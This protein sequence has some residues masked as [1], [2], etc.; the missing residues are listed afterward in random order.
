MGRSW[1]LLILYYAT[2]VGG[3][4]IGHRVAKKDASIRG[5]ASRVRL[6]PIGMNQI[7]GGSTLQNEITKDEKGSVFNFKFDRGPWWAY[8]IAGSLGG[9]IVCMCVYFCFCGKK[10]SEEAEP[11]T[12]AVTSSAEAETTENIALSDSLLRELVCRS[13]QRVGPALAKGQALQNTVQRCIEALTGNAQK[14]VLSELSCTAGRICKTLEAEEAMLVLDWDA[15]VR[16]NFPA[17]TVLLAGLLAPTILQL[18][19]YGHVTMIALLLL[20]VA[21]LC[22]WAAW[23]DYGVPC[24]AIPTLFTWLYVQGAIAAVLVLTRLVMVF[25]IRAGQAKLQSKAKEFQEKRNGKTVIDSLGE[26]QELFVTHSVLVQHAL[27]IEESVTKSLWS[28]I[29]G[30]GTLL[31]IIVTMWG[32]VL[33]LGWTFV[34]GIVAFHHDAVGVHDYCGAWATVF[35]ARLVVII[36]ILFFLTNVVSTLSWISNLALATPWFQGKA[37]HWARAFDAR[38]QGLPVMQVLFKAFV[39]P[40]ELDTASAQLAAELYEQTLMEQEYS[41]CDQR[42]KELK[43]QIHTQ[44]QKADDLRKKLFTEGDK[45]TLQADLA[46]LEKKSKAAIEKGRKSVEEGRKSIS[47]EAIEA[48]KANALTVEEA[49]TQELERVFNKIREAAEAGKGKMKEFSESEQGQQVRAAVSSAGEKVTVAAERT[50]AVAKE[51]AAAAQDQA[52][53]SMAKDDE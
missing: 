4:F 33:V 18:N 44:K 5:G 20:P 34:P 52:K 12:V 32:T 11:K 39:L 50:A 6:A 9:L 1:K 7:R 30:F 41:T 17:V 42:V 2:C 40:R 27:L 25:Q 43:N 48:A 24:A 15:A 22:A 10:K 46:A 16:A 19:L 37:R 31:W 49:S 28:K 3:D 47:A 45:K 8:F 36:G 51:K 13:L 38:F 26:L 23:Q 35:V 29:V 14:L 21:I 53:K